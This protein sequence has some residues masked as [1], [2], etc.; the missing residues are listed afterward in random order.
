MKRKNFY[1]KKAC[2]Y[3]LTGK[4]V[5]ISM[6][7]AIASV[8]FTHA[9]EDVTS[10]YIKNPGF[11]GGS[12][13][14]TDKNYLVPN[15]WILDGI[16]DLAETALRNTGAY[17]GTYRYY[18]WTNDGTDL[19]F[20]QDI[21][22]PAGK[23]ALK[24]A[25]R[26]LVAGATTLYVEEGTKAYETPAEGNW[27][28]WGHPTITFTVSADEANVRI[29]VTS[30]QPFM[31]D[32]FRLTRFESN[33]G[34]FETNCEE[35]E[36]YR[37]E[38]LLLGFTVAASELTA[39]LNTYAEYNENTDEADLDA[40][41]EVMGN[42]KEI[43]STVLPHCSTLKNSV[44]KVEKLLADCENGTYIV[45]TAI[46]EALDSEIKEA[47]E[48]MV[49][50]SLEALTTSAK[51]TTDKLNLV[52]NSTMDSINTV[53]NYI[54]NRSFEGGSYINDDGYITP[55]DWKLEGD[56]VNADISL[57]NTGA[58]DGKWRY[59]IWAEADT[60]LDFY[61]DVTL[62]AG[63]YVLKAATKP[64]GAD[65]A[66]LYVQIGGAK[67]IKQAAEGGWYGSWGHPSIAFTVPADNTTA[68]I[69]II[70]TGAIMLDNF[71]LYY[72]DPW[73]GGIYYSDNGAASVYGSLENVLDEIEENENITSLDLSEAEAGNSLTLR[74]VN[75]NG[76]VYNSPENVT[77]AQGIDANN[78]T[79][80][81]ILDE[82]YA[83]N[84][85]IACEEVNLQYVRNFEIETNNDNGGW[86][87]IVLPFDVETITAIQD[88]EEINLIP[89][90]QWDEM[91]KEVA[92]EQGLRP[93][94]LLKAAYDASITDE[95]DNSY[96]PADAIKANEPYLIAIPND[97]DFYAPY[98]NV[99]GDVTFNG[100]GVQ[101]TELYSETVEGYTLNTNFN[102]PTGNVYALNELGTAW[103]AG[104]DANS[105]HLY[106]TTSQANA[107]QRI[108]I[109]GNGGGTTGIKGI[110]SD[111]GKG[112]NG[113]GN[114]VVYGS[115]EGIVIESV[116]AGE[117][118]IYSVSGELVKIAQVKEGRSVIKVPAGVYI[119]NKNKVIVY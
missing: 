118:A 38:L 57:K 42:Q 72:A 116:K 109:F 51:E 1:F 44:D 112:Q 3:L 9:Q 73:E 11:E 64:D 99:S 91:G 95:E 89:F 81:F 67:A 106:V 5:L 111:F 85:P 59:Y 28:N 69:G 97:P 101:V 87:S 65:V 35:L 7:L 76:I 84:A 47:K 66:S 104:I 56:I 96:A 10:S 74:L 98:F 88:G 117:A 19:N 33:F 43:V 60:D 49:N 70:S 31:V 17:E 105:F 103:E 22:L 62:P 6:T 86:Q 15:D 54:I 93:F 36:R 21:T 12:Y 53:N 71:R 55:K 110:F 77:I 29:G 34:L 113:I 63:N 18:I 102:G 100:K 25:T 30:T 13:N 37:D 26:P 48:I 20:Y 92:E 52:Y 16:L 107:P 58:Q 40:T 4:R 79:T 24:A 82:Q 46:K 80:E 61:Q 23:Y 108:A 27:N 2:R 119:I 14:A 90:A 78:N 8:G 39:V 41:I 83:F 45:T 114:A 68:R 75:P 50:S 32:D 94:W 115:K